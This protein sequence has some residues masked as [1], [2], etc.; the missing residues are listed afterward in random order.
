MLMIRQGEFKEK[1]YRI[2]LFNVGVLVMEVEGKLHGLIE[3]VNE[4]KIT[5]KN[6]HKIMAYMLNWIC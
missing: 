6:V 5:E 3:E 1:D 4:V 2:G